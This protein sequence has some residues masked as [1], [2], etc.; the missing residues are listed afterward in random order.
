MKNEYVKYVVVGVVALLVLVGVYLF[1]S[2]VTEAPISAL[3]CDSGFFNYVVGKSSILVQSIGVDTKATTSV[4]CQF[5]YTDPN[6]TPSANKVDA[7]LEDSPT[8]KNWRCIEPEQTF[9]KGITKF[10][11]NVTDNR[12][13]TA[14]CKSQIYLP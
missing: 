11:V 8:G 9:P 2:Q 12:G 14:V 1:K 10:T 4:S 6:G 3:T 7:K 5:S 13:E